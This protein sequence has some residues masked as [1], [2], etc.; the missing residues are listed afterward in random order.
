[1]DA[2]LA[3]SYRFCENLA[4]REARHFYPAFRLLPDGQRRGMCALYA[5]MR[6]ADDFSDAS[7]P[8]ET[9]QRRLA[10][11]RLALQQA[12]AG[13]YTHPSHR[14]LHHTVTM[15]G[16]PSNYLEALIDGVEMDLAS[17]TYATF[18]DLRT[19]CW[20]VAS[21][22]GLACLPIWG[23]SDARATPLAEDAGIAFQLTN[24]LRDLK[25]DAGRGRIYLPQEDLNRFGYDAERL[26]GGVCDSDFRE[27]MRF[28]VE[29]AGRYY[30][31]AK[32]LEALLPRPG[33]TVFRL[34]ARTYRSL[35]DA[36]EKRDYD[37]FSRR[38]RVGRWRKLMLA[39]GTL[40]MRWLLR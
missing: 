17:A 26:R 25:E 38:V 21:V 19:Y 30:D 6:I 28:Q 33:R 14:A 36:I 10:D 27:L 1:M 31:S 9:K 4:R 2:S 11:W 7:G 40:P 29:R 39:M 23:C 32:P 34:M 24:I 15:F 13:V 8:I 18:A 22:V 16:V 12:L 5:F 20:H 35:L 37:V 3:E